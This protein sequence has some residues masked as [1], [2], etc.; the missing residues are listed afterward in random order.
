MIGMASAILMKA[1]SKR[2]CKVQTLV[3][4]L[5]YSGHAAKGVSES[6]NSKMKQCIC[7][8]CYMYMSTRFTH[9]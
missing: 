5:L 7:D 6:Y 9:D 8:V 4:S 1:R 3:A 2:M